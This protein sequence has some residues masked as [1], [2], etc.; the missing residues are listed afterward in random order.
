MNDSARITVTEGCELCWKSVRNLTY[1]L[2]VCGV[3]MCVHHVLCVQG[4]RL[5]VSW[6]ISLHLVRETV[7][8]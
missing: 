8:H 3:W 6:S 4:Q 5:I 7:S 2:C 1:S